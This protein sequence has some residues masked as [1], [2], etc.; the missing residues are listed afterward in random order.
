[1]IRNSP[2]HP[3]SATSD[4][5]SISQQSTLCNTI[6]NYSPS[7]I[8][9]I[10]HHDNHRESMLDDL[11]DSL[12]DTSSYYSAK[13]AST[14]T[15]VKKLEFNGGGSQTP[16]NNNNSIAY[17]NS[18]SYETNDGNNHIKSNGVSLFASANNNI[19][20]NGRLDDKKKSKLLAALKHID[21]G[22]SFEN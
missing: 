6:I 4:I 9:S 12:T 19:N 7:E 5:S 8:M 21:N 2:S 1:M 10:R 3:P 14:F 13:T 11:C 20:V 15:R 16:T 17:S 22:S 18:N